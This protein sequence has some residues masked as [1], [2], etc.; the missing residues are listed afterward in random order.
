VVA[1]KLWPLPDIF[2]FEILDDWSKTLDPTF[3]IRGRGGVKTGGMEAFGT[4]V[5]LFL[6]WMLL[7]SNDAI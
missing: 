1:L 2:S 7:F 6:T 4:G 5:E 3:L